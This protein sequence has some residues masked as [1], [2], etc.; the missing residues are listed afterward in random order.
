MIC[1]TL[2]LKFPSVIS[3]KILVI[4]AIRTLTGGLGLKEAKDMVDRGG[5]VTI[6]TRVEGAQSFSFKDA[7]V[8]AE[9]RLANALFDLGGEG[10]IVL[11]QAGSTIIPKVRQMIIDAVMTEEYDAAIILLDAIK[12]LR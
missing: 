9:V 5:E 6:E 10:V 4:K 8:S 12:R 7:W 1:K 11:E 2:K 3:N